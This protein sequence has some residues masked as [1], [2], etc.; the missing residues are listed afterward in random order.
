MVDALSTMDVPTGEV[1]KPEVSK[2]AGLSSP[3]D[4]NKAL[5]L[6]DSDS[7][8]SE[9]EDEDKLMEDMGDVANITA[10]APEVNTEQKDEPQPEKRDLGEILPDHYADDGRV[11]VFKPSMYQFEDFENYVRHC[12]LPNSAKPSTN[13]CPM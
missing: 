4:S 11:P 6:D 12:A 13:L 10:A 5:N 7:E 3:P 2:P 1:C 9:L 8:L